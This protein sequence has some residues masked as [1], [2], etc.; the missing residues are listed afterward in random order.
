GGARGI[1]HVAGTSG[2][3]ARHVHRE[4]AGTARARRAHGG[5]G[6]GE[7]APRRARKS[8]AEDR[9]DHHVARPG[10][11]VGEIADATT[12]GGKKPRLEGGVAAKIRGRHD[13]EHRGLAPLGE[14]QARRGIAVA[15]VVSRAG[16]DEEATGL[17][18]HPQR[19]LRHRAGRVLHQEDAGHAEFVD[20]LPIESPGLF[21]GQDAVHLLARWMSSTISR[22]A[23]SMPTS[24]DRATM[25]WPMLSSRI[26]GIAATGTTFT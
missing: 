25:A 13:R 5:D 23:R 24:T 4:H 18:D 15:A 19:A 17:P 11:E 21:G 12:E 2:T 8:R 3:A 20:R 22:T 10:S 14:E 26:S 1:E 9:V 7:D 6:L 16:D